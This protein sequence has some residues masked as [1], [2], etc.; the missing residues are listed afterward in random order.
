M[1]S[2]G[3]S[4]V[5]ANGIFL[6][7]ESKMS[8]GIRPLRRASST[9]LPTSRPPSMT[10]AANAAHPKRHHAGPA[11]TIEGIERQLAR[12]EWPHAL[13]RKRPMREKKIVPGLLHD[14]RT[15]GKRPRTVCCRLKKRMHEGS[16]TRRRQRPSSFD[17][18]DS[19]STSLRAGR[20][21]C[22]YA[23]L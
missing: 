4:P 5:A 14:P 13:R 12:N 17:R 20:S 23:I 10:A 7:L 9:A 1:S 16:L 15:G 22:P 18:P 11:V 19:P 21:G 3:I 6:I 2:S 8:N